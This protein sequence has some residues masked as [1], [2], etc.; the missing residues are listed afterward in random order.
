MVRISKKF[1]IES[2]VINYIIDL[3][4][5]RLKKAKNVIKSVI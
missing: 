4:L 1:L 3:D 5:S 2:V